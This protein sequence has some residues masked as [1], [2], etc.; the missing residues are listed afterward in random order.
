[1]QV[2]KRK[3]KGYAI[4][5]N[6]LAI[7]N[8]IPLAHWKVEAGLKL[9]QA[10][11]IN[12]ILFNSEAW[13]GIHEKDLILL[14]K[15]DEALLRG[16]LSAHPKIPIEALYLETKCLPIR[17]IIASRRIMYLHAIYQRDK[18]EMIRRILEAQINDPSPGDFS[19]ID[20]YQVQFL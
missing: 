15:V 2:E 5:A 11:F 1:M 8:E 16:L 12:G 18:N 17:F 3:S 10:M 13:Q 6:I 19:E 20:L 7:I 9:R 14:E 4:I